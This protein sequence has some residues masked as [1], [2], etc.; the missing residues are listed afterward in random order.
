MSDHARTLRTSRLLLTPVVASDATSL[1]PLMSESVRQWL[2]SWP[3]G[4]DAS[5]VEHRISEIIAETRRGD[6]LCFVVRLLEEERVV[7]WVQ[8]RRDKRDAG[9]ANLSYWL[10]EQFH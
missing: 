10:G 4:A 7:G 5:S 8:I 1:A 3:A 9:R 2:A 6:A